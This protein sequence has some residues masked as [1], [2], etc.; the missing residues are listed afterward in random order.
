[1]SNVP[2]A[3]LSHGVYLDQGSRSIHNEQQLL[4]GRSTRLAT[5]DM[6][7][8]LRVEQSKRPDTVTPIPTHIPARLGNLLVS[9]VTGR[10]NLNGKSVHVAAS[11]IEGQ[12]ITIRSQ[13]DLRGHK[14][15]RMPN[16][17]F[18]LFVGYGD[19]THAYEGVT[20][21][22]R[23]KETIDSFLALTLED[24][25]VSTERSSEAMAQDYGHMRRG[26][27]ALA[28]LH[29]R[30]SMDA[31][32][33]YFNAGNHLVYITGRDASNSIGLDAVGNITH[34]NKK[35][36]IEMNIYGIQSGKPGS[37]VAS[38]VGYGER[39]KHP[40]KVRAYEISQPHSDPRDFNNDEAGAAIDVFESFCGLSADYSISLPAPVLVAEIYDQI[41]RRDL[42]VAM[43]PISPVNLGPLHL[44]P[45]AR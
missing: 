19:P 5:A 40:A 32:G 42:E 34:T 20:T 45:E 3:V 10:P 30:E 44:V 28:L 4:H 37:L 26:I 27:E 33:Y 29:G 13:H 1:M 25:I 2:K 16:W 22:D 7:W 9:S 14:S 6:S 24:I 21:E 41:Q 15:P 36:V 39:G 23:G 43:L 31:T 18:S 11:G 12:G 8:V 35:E 17:P 38:A